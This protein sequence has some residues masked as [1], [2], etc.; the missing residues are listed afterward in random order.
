LLSAEE[1]TGEAW[2]PLKFGAL[3]EMGKRWVEQYV[4]IIVN[5]S[6][7]ALPTARRQILDSSN[8]HGNRQTVP[9]V[10]KEKK[11][12]GKKERRKKGKHEND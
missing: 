12:E 10:V 6:N 9:L 5:C 11:K 7:V 2:E 1:Q 8:P 4:N 3:S